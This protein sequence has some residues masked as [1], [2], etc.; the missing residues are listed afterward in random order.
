[1]S[2][3]ENLEEYFAPFRANI[4]GINQTYD[5]PFG[6]KKIVYADWTASGRM[7]EAI[8]EIMKEKISPFVANTHT[9]TNVTGSSMTLAYKKARDIIKKHVNS[10][11][12]ANF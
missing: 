8:E 5:T 9:E 12:L 11:C 2:K 10:N 4:I 3:F 1:M 7:Y 6:S